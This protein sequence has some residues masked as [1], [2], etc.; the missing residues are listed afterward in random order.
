MIPHC[1]VYLWGC[2]V[3]MIVLLEDTQWERYVVL[4]VI[5][6][7]EAETAAPSTNVTGYGVA[8]A[9]SG[10]GMEDC[11]SPMHH[12]SRCLGAYRGN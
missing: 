4:E 5:W 10:L 2:S 7:D 8:A 3:R 11:P 12:P 9:A 6:R 1:Q